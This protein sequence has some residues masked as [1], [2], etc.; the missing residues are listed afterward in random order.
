M[1][2]ALFHRLESIQVE[3]A[4]FGEALGKT[5]WEAKR[6]RGKKA[7]VSLRFLSIVK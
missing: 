5:L 6:C 4:G 2:A 7:L 1:F 3:F